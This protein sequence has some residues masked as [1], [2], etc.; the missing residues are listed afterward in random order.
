MYAGLVSLAAR[1]SGGWSSTSVTLTLCAAAAAA[2]PTFASLASAAAGVPRR[3]GGPLGKTER[4]VL[5]LIATGLP[6][7][8]PW[9]SSLVVLGSVLTAGLRLR[10]A[11]RDLVA[12]DASEA[13]G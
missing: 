4:C 3:N 9:L 11:H 6:G 7:L 13:S 8:L 5:A 10:A 2:L 12:R 1:T